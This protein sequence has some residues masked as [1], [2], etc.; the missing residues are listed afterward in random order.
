MKGGGG[1]RAIRLRNH[2]QTTQHTAHNSLSSLCVHASQR[3]RLNTLQHF[4]N[5]ALAA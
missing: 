1:K 3:A 2:D 4:R 5:D